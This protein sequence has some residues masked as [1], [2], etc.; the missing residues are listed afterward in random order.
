MLTVHIIWCFRC[1]KNF[2]KSIPWIRSQLQYSMG[3]SKSCWSSFV[4]LLMKINR[5]A[6][7]SKGANFF[8]L[9]YLTIVTMPV[10]SRDFYVVKRPAGCVVSIDVETM[11]AYHQKRL[12][13]FICATL[14]NKCCPDTERKLTAHAAFNALRGRDRNNDL[15]TT[16]NRVNHVQHQVWHPCLFVSM[17]R[18]RPWGSFLIILSNWIQT[19]FFILSGLF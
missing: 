15:L 11:H 1:L 2:C 18:R 17:P 9:S 19:L 7:T 13:E 12:D 16:N 6:S 5:Q 8:V 10:V 4:N 3:I 14:A